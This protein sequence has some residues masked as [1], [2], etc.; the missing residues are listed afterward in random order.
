[1]SLRDIGEFGFINQISKGCLIRPRRVVKAIGDDAAAF[2]TP[3]HQIGLVT[4]DLLVERIHFLR[5]AITGF[6]LGYKSLAVNL[7]D[8]AAMGGSA[9]EAF[10]S[11][12][13]PDNCEIEYLEEFYRGMQ[14][15]AEK[16]EV[17]ILGG[18]TT[19]SKKDLV[20]NVAV[21]GMVS[22][23]QILYRDGAQPGDIVFCTGSLG[24]SRAGLEIIL[25]NIPADT[26]EKKRLIEAH[27][28]PEPHLNEG[29]LLATST[30]VHS[31]IDV[32]DGLV[33]DLGHILEAS[34]VGVKL[35]AADIP[36]SAELKK[37]CAESG[38]DPLRTALSGGEDYVLLGTC[39]ANRAGTL[40]AEFRKGFNRP[41][42]CIGEITSGKDRLLIH[43]DGRAEPLKEKG[44]NHF[45]PH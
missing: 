23:D 20:I 17:N 33:A 32:S 30:G 44:W 14:A 7:S 10:V 42:F 15:L 8:I 24:D 37:F 36:I 43:P 12:A 22:P 31:A 34:R 25:G 35:N 19:G 26:P 39:A 2:K 18:D 5:D 40:V 1:M 29:R 38:T 3:A 13:I 11:I 27:M 28:H 9:S 41:L 4:T 21:Y 6:D 16:F 45:S